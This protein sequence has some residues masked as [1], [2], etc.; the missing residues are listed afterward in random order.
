MP[1]GH[2]PFEL[3]IFAPLAALPYTVAFTVWYLA[4]LGL[5]LGTILVLREHILL[6]RER[7]PF[8]VLAIGCFYPV[9]VTI[10]QGQDSILLLFLF[11]LM[12]VSLAEKR[13]VTAGLLLSLCTVK[14]QLIFPT[15]VALAAA[16]RW[17]ALQAFASGC[18][19]VIFL[20]IAVVGLE[21]VTEYPRFL[22]QYSRLPAEVAAIYP[23]RMP[24]LRGMLEFLPKAHLRLKLLMLVSLGLVALLAFVFN[25]VR[26]WQQSFGIAFAACV[27]VTMLVAYHLNVH[28][29]V[30]ITLSL[31]LAADYLRGARP[32]FINRKI[33]FAVI[34][35][36]YFAPMLSGIYGVVITAGSI[37]V[38]A[39]V[40][41]RECVVRRAK[42]RYKAGNAEHVALNT[43]H[44][45]RT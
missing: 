33:M 16:R 24:N 34:F 11:S 8:V 44:S 7:L 18:V 30:L 41:M 27:S 25:R 38:F 29:V 21:G 12:F 20:S 42:I 14:F 9:I 15:V 39:L 43:S 35:V 22:A 13:D 45:A 5:L 28:D 6:V 10:L 26:S 19:L 37:S 2:P 1:F 32:F 3:L 31:L 23:E 36:V 17:K 40:L 4:N